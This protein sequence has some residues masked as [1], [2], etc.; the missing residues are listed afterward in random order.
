MKN[1]K[2][3]AEEQDMDNVGKLCSERKTLWK[4][5]YWQHY[6]MSIMSQTRICIALYLL[7]MLE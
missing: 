5:N 7:P 6:H 2:I 3:T 4:K 1:N